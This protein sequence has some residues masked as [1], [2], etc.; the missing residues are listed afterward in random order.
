MPS[1][2]SFTPIG[3][4]CAPGRTAPERSDI[5]P[6]AI[7]H[8]LA[9]TFVLEVTGGAQPRPRRTVFR[10]SG[11]RLDALFGRELRGTGF[12]RIWTGRGAAMAEAMLDGVLDDRA[13]AVAAVRGGPHGAEAIDLELLLLPLRHQGHT[14]AR[15]LGSLATAAAPGWMGLR[16]AAPLDMSTVR[17]LSADVGLPVDP[18][19][20]AGL[21]R[22]SRAFAARPPV[23]PGPVQVGPFRI[24]QG[25]RSGSPDRITP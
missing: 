19:E 18:S 4:R 8:I 24:Y 15:V 6:A 12:A 13:G 3:T 21:A 1:A 23:V 9:Y 20:V 5:D 14:H 16:A 7:R 10:L 22:P 2:S 11:T 17:N 25:G